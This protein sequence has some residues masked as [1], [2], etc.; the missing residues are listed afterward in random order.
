MATKLHIGV[1]L[2][3]TKFVYSRKRALEIARDELGVR[4]VEM[5]PDTDYGPVLFL[6][7]EAKFRAYHREVAEYGDK[8][9]VDIV[10]VLTFFRDSVSIAHHD[11][12]ISAA[13]WTVMESMVAQA[14]SYGAKLVGGSVGTV[15][16]DD[17]ADIDQRKKLFARTM[18]AWKRWMELAHREGVGAVNVEAMSTL[19]EPPATIPSGREWMAELCAFHSANPDTTTPA[20]FC[21]DLG[22]G[23][24]EKEEH[25]PADRDFA[26]WFE[27]FGDV[28][29]EVH[30]KNT[31]SGFISTWP[32]TDAY[33]E[34]GIIDLDRVAEGMRD[35]LRAPDVYVM[36]EYPGKRGRRDGELECIRGNVETI[37]NLKKSL[38]RAGWQEDAKDGTWAME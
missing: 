31:D 35:Y 6:K 4:C 16:A 34:T 14:G 37:D 33:K 13:A 26:A 7:N 32:F 1:N 2:N 36:V 17:F 11:P 27:A 25:S 12:D 9:G 8:I 29:A 28:I 23:P 21:Y 22:H 30:I 24:T 18:D 20:T 3:F 5:V 38:K 19:R 10:S 15:L